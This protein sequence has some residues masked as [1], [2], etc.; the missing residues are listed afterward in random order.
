MRSSGEARLLSV[1][2]SQITSRPEAKKEATIVLIPNPA[3]QCISVS[4][5]KNSQPYAII[6][7]DGKELRAGITSGEIDVSSLS[8]G[9][10]LLRLGGGNEITKELIPVLLLG[11]CP[12]RAWA[13][14]VFL[15]S[16]P[17]GQRI[18]ASPPGAKKS[19]F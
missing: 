12:R 3:A 2:T 8:A 16:F 18:S 15:Q 19:N 5:L 10:Y 7:S 1:L 4:G 11:A 6:Q 9:M 17:C 13:P 14:G